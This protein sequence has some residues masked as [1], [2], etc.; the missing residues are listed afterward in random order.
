MTTNGDGRIAL[1]ASVFSLPRAA[2]S[3]FVQWDHTPT[4]TLGGDI[5]EVDRTGFDRLLKAE[6]NRLLRNARRPA[7]RRDGVVSG[8]PTQRLQGPPATYRDET[9]TRLKSQPQIWDIG[10]GGEQSSPAALTALDAYRVERVSFQ[11]QRAGDKPRLHRRLTS[12]AD[13]S[14]HT[15]LE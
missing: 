8:Y 14:G 10:A 3:S 9:K 12:A 4:F 5:S 6:P 15:R 2:R 11:C 13:G 1:S 7:D